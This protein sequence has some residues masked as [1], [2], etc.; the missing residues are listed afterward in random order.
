MTEDARSRSR[1]RL[2]ERERVILDAATKLFA[3]GGF[4]ATSTRKIAATAGVS[5]GT[6]FHY[7]GSKNALMLGI[8][9]RFYHEVLNPRAAE[10]LDTIMDTHSRIR[11]LA[12]HHSNALAKDNALMMRLLQ[13]YVGVDFEY[14]GSNAESPLRSLNRHYVH[15]FD[16][17]L[18]EG[19]ERGD[20]RNDLSIRPLRDL[21]FGTLEYGLRTHVCARAEQDLEEYVDELIAPLWLGMAARASATASPDRVVKRLEKICDRLE[22][23][24]ER[25]SSAE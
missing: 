9:D 6:V 1:E 2:E 12:R 13:V 11:A 10:I 4:H 20:L 7:F 15:Y 18:R 21:F 19:I 24:A 8:L 17:I 3:S 25:R 16:R 22:A 23:T 5:E 14:L